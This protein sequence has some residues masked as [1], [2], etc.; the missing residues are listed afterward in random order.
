MK[1]KYTIAV[2]GNPNC[3]KTTLFNSLTGGKQR[4]G[5]WPGVTVE[6]KEG[7]LKIN[8]IEL[9][10]VDLPGIYSL[11]TF[12]EDEKAARDYILSG[13]P[14]LIVN[15]V[16]ATNLERNLYLTFQLIEMQ[17]PVLIILNMMDVAEKQKT[18]IDIDILSKQLDL[19][20]IG[21]SA[22]NITDIEKV[23]K[24]IIE[25]IKNGHISGKS[26][27]Y[28]NEIEDVIKQWSIR[29]AKFSNE[30]KMGERWISIKILE[31]DESIKTKIIKSNYL[32]NLEIDK[33]K[34]KIEKVLKNSPDIILADYRYGFIHGITKG[35][36]KRINTKLDIT[37]KI[38]KITLHRFLGVPIFLFAIYLVFWLTINIGGVFVDFFDI[39]SGTIF[40]DATRLLLVKLNSPLWLISLLSDGVG[41]GIQTIST[42]I[43]IIFI[44]FFSLS[45]LEDSGYMARGAFLM[46]RYMKKIGLPGKSFVPLIVGF[47]CTVPAVMATRTLE[48]KSDRYLTVFM[49]PLMSCGARLPVYALFSAAF[50]PKAIGG[51]IVFSLYLVGIIL[52]VLVA[53]M[54]KNT[55]F[56]G[57]P[58]YFIME[59]PPYNT[60]RIKHIMLHTWGRLKVFIFKAGKMIIIAI[61]ILGFL[62]SVTIEGK[63]SNKDSQ[64]TILA[65]IGRIITPI[66]KPMGIDRENWPA[67]VALLT[68]L[69]AKESI[70]STMNALYTQID[71]QNE[72]IYKDKE[73]F[74]FFNKI[75]EAFISVPA[76]IVKLFPAE[77]ET[78]DEYFLGLIKNNFKHDWKSAYSYLLFILV[79][80]PCVAAFGAILREVGTLI[81]IVQVT[82]LT[83]L[84][85]IIGTLF[86]QFTAGCQILWIVIPLII[87]S[88]FY[89]L[90]YLLGKLKVF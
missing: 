5:N 75:K 29:L 37:D 30:I 4:I 58:S 76:N 72:S 13:E 27:K 69:F 46:D 8:D 55:L 88:A 57:E 25:A 60:L 63:I 2:A 32:N 40:V 77:Q 38:D 26:I 42:F 15:I 73:S 56:K 47:G 28:P 51:N 41:T 68:G 12:S 53:L 81:G 49:S 67:S 84:G 14:D 82:F 87:L 62:N 85:W 7:T 83:V 9:N 54:L 24:N 66:F 74:N 64:N 48:N 71:S 6:K 70:V 86:Y 22:I 39:I 10:I 45:A 31:D 33:G 65:K 19:P 11:S 44:M 16:D 23:K 1:N 90:F 36:I 3:G 34:N 35:I 78:D 61:T 59:L 18:K 80:F 43:P 17:K 21:I 52:A 89:L 79:Y 50:F 20:A